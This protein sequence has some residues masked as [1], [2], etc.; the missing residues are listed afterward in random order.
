M[1]IEAALDA[2]LRGAVIRGDD[3][4]IEIYREIYEGRRSLNSK[5]NTH[6]ERVHTA[7]WLGIL[8]A[9]EINRG[10]LNERLTN[11]DL[12]TG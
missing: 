4:L 5:L 2:V 8:L 11:G 9:R 12:R 7:L 6:E 10:E 3:T 1:T